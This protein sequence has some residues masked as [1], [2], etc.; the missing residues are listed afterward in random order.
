MK[1]AQ[2]ALDEWVEFYNTDRPHQSLQ[3][4]TPAQLPPA[5]P[6]HRS[7]NF[8]NE[9]LPDKRARKRVRKCKTLLDARLDLAAPAEAY[10]KYFE[11]RR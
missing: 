7:R 8:P 4:A 2:Q 9:F 3:M 1:V 11:R 10:R 6:R 5:R